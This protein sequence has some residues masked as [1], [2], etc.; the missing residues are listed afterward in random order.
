[1]TMKT[2]QCPLIFYT[3]L[4]F[5]MWHMPLKIKVLESKSDPTLHM[6]CRSTIDHVLIDFAWLQVDIPFAFTL[7]G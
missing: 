1:M 3:I 5:Q 2:V 6:H 7:L 4:R